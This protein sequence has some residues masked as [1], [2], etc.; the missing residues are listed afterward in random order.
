MDVAYLQNKAGNYVAPGTEGGPATL[1]SAKL[2]PD[3]RLWL[4]DP[5]GDKAYPIAT[6]TWMLFYKKY[7]D[8][9]KSAAI[10]KMI[11]FGLA[12]GQKMADKM[13]YLPMPAAVAAEVKKASANIN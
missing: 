2:P 3:M 5:A 1:A 9:K 6:Y 13:G 4:S 8:P 10:R 7:D 11:D 12:E